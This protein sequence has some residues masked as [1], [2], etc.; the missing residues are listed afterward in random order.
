[1][2]QQVVR[3]KALRPRA[4]PEQLDQLVQV[5]TPMGWLTLLALSGL[6]VVALLWG[7]LGSVPTLTTAQGI[8]ITGGM[9]NRIAAPVAGEVREIAVA[10]GDTVKPGQKVAR[11]ASMTVVSSYRGRVVQILAE[12]GSYV[13]LGAPILTIEPAGTAMQVI[14]YAPLAEAKNIRPGMKVQISPTTVKREE[15]GFMLGT[16]SS[17][18][19]FPSTSESIKGT[20][21]NDELVK[22]FSQISVPVEIHVALEL[23]PNAVSGYKWSS[24]GGPPFKLSNGTLA[25]VSIIVEEQAPISL[26]FPFFKGR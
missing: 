18:A 22:E 21:V 12:K 16:I 6:I 15:Y 2:Q 13:G 20:L 24:P 23:D 9:V 7:I 14:V 8:L 26:I 11:V 3:E 25:S 5:T 10:V 4:S 17:V 1:M 19:E